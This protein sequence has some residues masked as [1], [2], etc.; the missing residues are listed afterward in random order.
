MLCDINCLVC[1]LKT[2]I[3]TELI[4]SILTLRRPDIG[5]TRCLFANTWIIKPGLGACLPNLCFIYKF[6]TW[7]VLRECHV[8]GSGLQ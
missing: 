3:N 2:T 4:I 7:L 5:S 8:A 1:T 6:G